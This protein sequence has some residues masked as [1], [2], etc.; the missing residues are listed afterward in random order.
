MMA[1]CLK[2]CFEKFLSAKSR[3]TGKEYWGQLVMPAMDGQ[4]KKGGPA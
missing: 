3:F 2:T 1:V 4:G